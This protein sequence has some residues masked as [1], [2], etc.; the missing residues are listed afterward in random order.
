MNIVKEPVIQKDILG[1]GI[2]CTA[3][4]LCINYKNALRLFP[5]GRQK[6]KQRGFICKEIVRVLK[7]KDISAHYKYINKKIRKKIY[8]D[9][10]IVFI[11]R[12]KKYPF[13]HYLVRYKNLWMDP[14]INFPENKNIKKAISGFRKRLPGRPIYVIF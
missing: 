4:V 11:K 9:N 3:F 10:V 8:R 5:D 2:A 13:G 12:S 14:W 6:A 1:C 7:K